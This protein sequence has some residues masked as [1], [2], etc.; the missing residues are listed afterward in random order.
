MHARL[1]IACL[2]STVVSLAAERVTLVGKVTDNLGKPLDDATVM[3]YHAGVKKGYNIY[4]PSCY[5][6]CG[7]RTVTDRAGAFTISGL[8]PDLW[9]ELL[10]VRDGYAPAFVKKVDPSQGPAGTAT[11]APRSPVD[12]PARVARGIVVDSHGQPVRAAVVEPVGVSFEGGRSAYGTLEGLEPVAVTNAKG[13]FELAYRSKATGMMVQVEARGMAPKIISIP[14]GADRT[15]ITVADG[16]VVRG[17]LLNGGK[18]VSGA[19]VGLIAK[20][21][22]GYGGALRVFGNPYPEIRIGT[23]LD[24][25]FVIPN[26]PANVDWYVYGK[27][28]S[29][30]SLGAADPVECKTTRDGDDVNAGDVLIHPGHRLRGQ[31]SLS[32]GAPIA[33]NMRISI[34][35]DRIWDTQT[36]TIG[37]DGRFEFTGLPAGNFKLWTS[38]RGYQMPGQQREIEVAVDRDINDFAVR[39]EPA[40]KR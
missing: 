28:E 40:A 19:E 37:R 11:L 29:I 33:N 16:A 30:A 23:Q 32:D 6:D 39:L 1:L 15:K 31:V 14:T 10:V 7:K 12:Q 4:C 35:T 34:E 3:I 27:M 9:F 25:T 36:V 21:R 22:G 24:G 20:E 2:T 13:E 17:R 5:V 38:V 26:V 8:D 18:P